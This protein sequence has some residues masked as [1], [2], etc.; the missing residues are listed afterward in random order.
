MPASYAVTQAHRTT[1]SLIGMQGRSG[2]GGAALTLRVSKGGTD[3]W[4]FSEHGQARSP[5]GYSS[6]RNSD[7]RGVASY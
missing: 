5:E 2:K 3:E 1:L 6:P 4:P 7:K